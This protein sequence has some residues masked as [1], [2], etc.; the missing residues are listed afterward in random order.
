MKYFYFYSFWIKI[1]SIYM[2][3]SDCQ[4]DVI[5]KITSCVKFVEPYRLE[6]FILEQI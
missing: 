2:F 6:Q 4:L 5:T 3:A 1:R